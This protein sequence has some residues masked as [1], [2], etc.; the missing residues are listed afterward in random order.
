[1]SPVAGKWSP[2]FMSTDKVF[3]DFELYEDRRTG[4]KYGRERKRLMLFSSCSNNRVSDK[5]ARSSP[6]TRLEWHSFEERA[7][8]RKTLPLITGSLSLDWNHLVCK[9]GEFREFCAV[10]RV[11]HVVFCPRRKSH[12]LNT[13]KTKKMFLL[14]SRIIVLRRGGRNCELNQVCR[15]DCSPA[16]RVP[17]GSGRL[18]PQFPAQFQPCAL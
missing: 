4:P 17:A 1:M 9:F 7:A 6:T 18:D 11:N 5:I 12:A 2:C 10:T 16:S 8:K 14:L 13:E 15:R 3:Q